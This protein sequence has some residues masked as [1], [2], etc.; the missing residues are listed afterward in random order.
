MDQVVHISSP[1]DATW[2]LFHIIV[3]ML[4][5]SVHLLYNKTSYRANTSLH[6]EGSCT[7]TAKQEGHT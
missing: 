1:P 3:L 6:D 2:W 7:H 4:A 5:A